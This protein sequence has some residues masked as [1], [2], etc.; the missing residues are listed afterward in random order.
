MACTPSPI[1]T[2]F[3]TVT[4]SSTST[5]FSSSI[6][7]PSGQVTTIVTQ[8]CI[9]SGTL[10]GST[11][12]GCLLSTEV[13]QVSTIQGGGS[14][15]QVPVVFTVPVVQTE[16]TKTLF[17]TDCSN[18]DPSGSSG[19]TTTSS[20]SPSP[21]SSTETSQYASTSVFVPTT[22]PPA[23]F[24]S[25]APTT[26]SDGSVVLTYV[27]LTSYLLPSSVYA[28]PSP[29]T[30]QG[31]QNTG[32]ASANNVAPIVGGIVG[33][34]FGLIAIVS[35]VWFILRR[36]KT[37]DDIFEKE[38]MEMPPPRTARKD[39]N[40]PD[41]VAEPKP[42]QYGLVGHITPP[43]ASPPSSPHPST[44]LSHP[45]YSS[46]GIH[47]RQPS[48]LSLAPLLGP[49]SSV[50][51]GPSLSRPSTAGSMQT[52]QMQSMSSGQRRSTRV[53]EFGAR[54]LSNATS[55]GSTTD[56]PSPTPLTLTNWNPN[57]DD[58]IDVT[59]THSGSPT[60]SPQ[61]R[62]LQL[63]NPPLSPTTSITSRNRPSVDQTSPK[64]SQ[65]SRA[66]ASLTRANSDSF[67]DSHTGY[68]L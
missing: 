61:R 48:A 64:A 67:S 35:A 9:S 60:G 16:A 40:R 17:T 5:S 38:A 22:P 37:W 10:S 39:W 32:A 20:T 6:A 27:T 33:G 31:S 54:P 11:N 1:E 59:S 56:R 15:A 19:T 13:T 44:S 42:Y 12:T 53:D 68:A 57:T 26:L 2:Q 46:S 45:S 24:T 66:S 25:Q 43:G 21:T 62:I 36:R 41:S 55:F 8:S 47:T 51:P 4:S 29:S 18:G 34:F 50:S 3:A 65:P 30:T 49:T 58:L 7:S 52:I 63:V 14:T 23:T 28:G